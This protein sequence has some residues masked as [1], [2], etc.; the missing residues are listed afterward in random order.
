MPGCAESCAALP[1]TVKLSGIC[2]II[3]LILFG[4]GFG[5]QFWSYSEIHGYANEG[6]WVGC[7]KSD[8]R[9]IF[10]FD[11]L[12]GWF[13]I[14]LVLECLGL[15]ASIASVM[16]TVVYVVSPSARDSKKSSILT[17]LVCFAAA[18][19]ILIGVT[20]YGAIVVDNLSWSFATCTAGGIFYG[21]AGILFL[22]NMCSFSKNA[23]EVDSNIP[24]DQPLKSS[25][26]E[27]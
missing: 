3:G 12:P 22:I 10:D 14:T 6:L 17:T 19:S 25:E 13:I 27:Q 24:M 11:P 9:K 15:L 23:Y 5:T 8:C 2:V 4:S 18:V 16:L 21:I 26:L 7:Y 20:I 1:I